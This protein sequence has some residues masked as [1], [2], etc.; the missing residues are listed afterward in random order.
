M[1]L[2]TIN[3]TGCGRKACSQIEALLDSGC[4]LTM[5]SK[6]RASQMGAILLDES[7]QIVGVTGHTFPAELGVV[8]L[9]VGGQTKLTL[10]GIADK[11]NMAGHEAIV[12]SDIMRDNC[13][14]ISFSDD[15]GGAIGVSCKC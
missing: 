9:T 5:V 13:C 14:V 12:G 7:T 10:V 15:L 3:I 8:A 11:K 1:K 6:E 2:P 4:S